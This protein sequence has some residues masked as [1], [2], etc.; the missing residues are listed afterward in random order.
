MNQNYSWPK[1]AQNAK[2]CESPWWEF[3]DNPGFAAAFCSRPSRFR[4]F[5]RFWCCLVV[6]A[7]FKKCQ[8]L[9]L[10]QNRKASSL[11]FLAAKKQLGPPYT[12]HSR[13]HRCSLLEPLHF[14]NPRCYRLQA[15]CYP[16]KGLV[17][18]QLKNRSGP[19][20][21]P[22]WGGT[23]PVFSP[24]FLSLWNSFQ[25]KNQAPDDNMSAREGRADAR[26][27]M[28]TGARQAPRE[29]EALRFPRKRAIPA[30]RNWSDIVL[31]V[32]IK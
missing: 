16:R 25:P 31:K 22:Q 8:K 30:W 24:N 7:S 3:H 21:F 6:A 11:V 9:Q 29:V 14:E 13:A 1:F 17:S 19:V 23:L 18:S 12:F 26:G 2:T 32:K 20:I 4:F 28:T 10:M 5:S 27:A 15:I